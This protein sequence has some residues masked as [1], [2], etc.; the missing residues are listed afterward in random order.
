MKPRTI[1][2]FGWMMLASVAYARLPSITQIPNPVTRELQQLH[3]QVERDRWSQELHKL[4]R[5]KEFFSDSKKTPRGTKV[6]AGVRFYLRSIQTDPSEVLHKEEIDRA[7]APWVGRDIQAQDLELIVRAI[8]Q[9]YVEKGFAVCRATLRPQR[10]RQ[11]NLHITLIEGKTEAVE[12]QG[13]QHTKPQY[14][15][16][17]FSL[18]RGKVANYRA[19]QEDLVRFNMTNDVVLLID[20]QPGQE[21]STTRYVI[22]AQEPALWQGQFFADTTGSPS[23]GRPKAGL[24]IT[25]TSLLGWR[26]AMTVLGVAS[27]GSQS[28]LLSYALPLTS[29]GTKLTGSLSLGRVHIVDGPSAVFDVSGRSALYTLRLEHPFWVSD[30]YKVT[31]FGAGSLQTSQTDMFGDLTI[32]DMDNQAWQIGLEGFWLGRSQVAMGGVT[33]SRVKA[34]EDVVGQEAHYQKMTGQLSWRYQWQPSWT[35]SASSAFQVALG[36]DDYF[37]SDYFFL[38]HTSGVRGYDNDIVSAEAGYWLNLQCSKS[39]LDQKASVY[40]FFDIG[41]LEGR[42]AYAQRT[43]SATGLGL[44]WPLF[45]GGQISSTVA[46]PLKKHLGEGLEDASR[47]RW[48]LSVSMVW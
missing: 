32:N 16:R 7:V 11:G 12:V 1:F 28:F 4:E 19:M 13:A 18:E 5:K 3:D 48:D 44:T 30:T 37:S 29:M 9:L 20:I 46:F 34:K 2:W 40:V 35:F 36:G 43:L 38:G 31:A 17:A 22:H 42:S 15:L 45:E 33:L 8:N 21:F 6:P 26:D 47:A 39:F 14:I 25:N 23:T 24:S 27:Q 41:R 10:I